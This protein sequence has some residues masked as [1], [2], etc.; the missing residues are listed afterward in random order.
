SEGNH[1]DEGAGASQEANASEGTE[2]SEET[3]TDENSRPSE[4][5]QAS[6]KKT[7]K[8]SLFAKIKYTIHA[9]CDKIKHIGDTI[10][11]LSD[12]I[13]YYKSVLTDEKNKQ[14]YGR[15]WNRILKVLKS[16]RP[17]VLK[18]NLRIGTGS[19]DTTGYLC[20]IY[21]MLLPALGNHVHMEADFEEAVWEGDVYAKG[22]ITIFTILLQAGKLLLDKQLRIF[23]KELKRE[24]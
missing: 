24:D 5:S 2:S 3:H 20:G 14:F 22:R 15:V 1:A 23:I 7:A 4:N 12:N 19:P 21:G 13:S 9:I 8:K 17:R 18:A 6:D 11:K 10:K 16:I